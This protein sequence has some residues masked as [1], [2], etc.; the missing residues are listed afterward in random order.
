MP[1][2]I[3]WGRNRYKL[4][5][6]AHE[7]VNNSTELKENRRATVILKVRNVCIKL[8]ECVKQLADGLSWQCGKVYALNTI[9]V[10]N[11]PAVYRQCI[12]E[13]SR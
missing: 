10:C 6:I 13:F 1:N 7:R 5:F 11:Q 9:I 4:Y 8:G 12:V 3:I 2:K